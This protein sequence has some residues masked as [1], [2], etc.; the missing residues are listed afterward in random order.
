MIQF[1]PQVVGPRDQ[2]GA[3]PDCVD[4]ALSRV[5]DGIFW[6]EPALGVE[7]ER[8]GKASCDELAVFLGGEI[9]V[10]RYRL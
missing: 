2:A 4:R 6:A 5:Q 3:P 1:H 9:G 10:D 8:P 7:D